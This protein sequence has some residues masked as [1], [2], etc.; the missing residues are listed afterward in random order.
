MKKMGA[1][2]VIYSMF[3][4]FIPASIILAA[5]A[6]LKVTP[7]GDNTLAISDGYALY[8]NYLGYVGRAL[9]GQESILYSFTKG[10]GGNMM[11][12]WGWFLLNPFFVLYAFFDIAN[13]MQAYTWVSL[14]NFSLCGLTMY[15]LLK[16]CYGHRLS[17]LIFSTAYALNGFLVANVFQMNFFACVP[18]LPIVVLGLKRILQSKSPLIYTLSLAY[19]LLMN[20][21]FGF[22]LCIVSVL[23]FTVLYAAE[24]GQIEDRKAVVIK[25][26]FSSI[27]A[28][29]L[30]SVIWLPALLSLRGGR[31]DQNISYA[32]SFKENM[33]FLDM[34]SK[35]F[36]GAN[37]TAEL[38]NGLPNIFVGILPVFLVI[39]FFINKKV[40]KKWKLTATVLLLF[41]LISFYIPVFNIA[42]HGGTVTN[43][44][45]YRDSFVFCFFLLMIAAEEW[46]HIV[47]EPGDNLKRATIIVIVTTLIVFS[48]RY[49]YVA[50]SA[51]LIDLVILGLMILALMMHKKDPVKNP[52]QIMTVIVLILM[53]INLFMNYY[54]STKNIMSFGKK[55]SDYQKVVIPVSATVDAVKEYDSDF[56]RMEIGE[57]WSGNLGNDPMLYG[58]YGVGH[59]GSDERDFVR[60]A[61]SKLG[62]RRYNMRNS[63]GSGVPAATDALLGLRYVISKDNL[64]EEKGYERLLGIEDWSLYRNPYTLPIVVLSDTEINNTEIDLENI[65]DNLNRTWSSVSG[66]T[67]PIF[68][69]EKDISFES[70]NFFDP[71]QLSYEEALK[72]VSERDKKQEEKLQ[73]SSDDVLVASEI[74]EIDRALQPSASPESMEYETEGSFDEPPEGSSYIKYTITVHRDGPVYSY[75]RSGMTDDNGSILPTMFYEGTY[76]AGDIIT[77]YLPVPGNIVAQSLLEDVAG[78]FR[79]VYVDMEAL[80]S[81]SEE[82]RNRP[83]ETVKIVDSHIRGE[84]TAE[85]RQKLMF[86]IPYDEGWR[87]YIDGEEA[88]INMVLN[89]FM[90]VD[91]P[92]GTHSY[93]MKFFP[94]GMKTG[95]GISAAALLTTIVYIPMDTKRRKQKT[96]IQAEVTFEESCGI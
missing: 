26:C 30:S 36:T 45:N 71:V 88:L 33:P 55:E 51:A 23:L 96:A 56:Y 67:I 27:I 58:Y 14:L 35:F 19:S 70:H 8:L 47:E 11:G 20:F 40:T 69:E 48:K 38:S 77:K 21:Y 62:V 64:T 68:I 73:N 22:M 49:E 89:V 6:G 16:D 7:F 43:W 75:N 85:A 39:L 15:I 93:E 17:N 2:P 32:I 24:R 52:N 95:I 9:K 82:I 72:I 94:T 74:S 18:A 80:A 63:Y 13:Y 42:M 61:L 50:G 60:T 54:F 37:S 34:L 76:Q 65:F 84:F 91:V 87:C 57:Q 78:R 25:Y 41:Y 92:E 59:G 86:T 12:S 1:R 46:N 66:D 28:G 29:A 79:T 5:L 44:F 10:L 90:A 53:C 3:S 4:F 83:V 31:L 81:L